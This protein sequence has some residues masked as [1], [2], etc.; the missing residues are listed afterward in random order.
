M[1]RQILPLLAIVAMS[2]VS[3]KHKL[4]ACESEE[5]REALE[6]IFKNQVKLDDSLKK[7]GY[8]LR[9]VS[10][11]SAISKENQ[12]PR[13]CGLTVVTD[14]TSEK[15]TY[16]ITWVSHKKGRYEVTLAGLW[17]MPV[18]DSFWVRFKIFEKL[19][20]L[21]EKITPLVGDFVDLA[22][23]NTVGTSPQELD[24][25]YEL[26]GSQKTMPLHVHVA[27]N[28]KADYPTITITPLLPKKP[29]K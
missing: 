17:G 15:L 4:P 26:L 16:R 2:T 12:S 23:I 19:P 14:R 27:A 5:A 7:L 24:C 29:K 9:E 3:C 25:R 20:A 8:K 6:N 10:G 21:M 1:I 28:P 22:L 11:F 13:L 18:C